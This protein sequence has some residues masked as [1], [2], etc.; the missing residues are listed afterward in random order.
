MEL[1]IGRGTTEKDGMFCTYVVGRYKPAG[2]M[3]GDFQKEVKKGSFS[4][5]ICDK[6]DEMMDKVGSGK[7]LFVI[8]VSGKLRVALFSSSQSLSKLLF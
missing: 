3:M 4:R 5:S 6:L 8:V 1:G 2:N 7:T